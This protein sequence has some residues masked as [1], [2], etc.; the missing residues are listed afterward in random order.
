M[1]VLF[2]SPS[3]RFCNEAVRRALA[4]Q[5]QQQNRQAQGGASDKL[6]L[7]S[8]DNVAHKARLPP[9]VDRV[10]LIFTSD[11]QVLIE[12]QLLAFLDTLVAAASP[13][14]SP[15]SSP[16][17]GDPL[18]IEGG[19]T[20][21]FSWLEQDEG[22]A[23]SVR[24]QF[25]A[26]SD[27]GHDTD[28]QRRAAAQAANGSGGGGGGGGID[29]MMARQQGAMRPPEHPELPD[30]LKPMVVSRG[31]NADRQINME[32]LMAARELEVGIGAGSGR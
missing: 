16:D 20:T 19:D 28:Q 14:V 5:E 1:N 3:C 18:A 7:V 6:V 21:A 25:M 24:N 31:R 27:Q 13:L 15:T 22:G 8:V 9:F 11:R 26:V 10:P 12:G 2:Y 30:H 32:A 29:M 23:A 4:V 17:A